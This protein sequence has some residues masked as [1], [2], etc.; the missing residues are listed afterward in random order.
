[1]NIILFV[2][3]KLRDCGHLRITGLQAAVKLSQEAPPRLGR[4][5]MATAS[6]AVRSAVRFENDTS[7][8]LIKP[9]RYSDRTQLW[10]NL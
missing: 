10:C 1:M 5:V 3:F 7:I 2:F 8:K 9:V 4:A 6:D